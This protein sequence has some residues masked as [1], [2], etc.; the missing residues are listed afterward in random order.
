MFMM[1]RVTNS[2]SNGAPNRRQSISQR[3]DCKHR[4]QDCGDFGDH[5]WREGFGSGHRDRLARRA[6]LESLPELR[7]GPTDE[8]AARMLGQ[9]LEFSVAAQPLAACVR[10]LSLARL[11]NRS[12]RRP[13][14]RS[15]RRAVTTARSRSACTSAT[16]RTPRA[17]VRPAAAAR[18]FTRALRRLGIELEH[19]HLTMTSSTALRSPTRAAS[20]SRCSRRARSRPADWNPQNVTACG[21]F[22]EYSFATPLAL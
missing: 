5:S 4:Q 17:D 7:S 21:E 16:I 15:V 1:S 3:G 19:A 12:G 8:R 6:H 13:A 18:L 9:F 2:S 20:R 11:S 14:G 22:L 10:V